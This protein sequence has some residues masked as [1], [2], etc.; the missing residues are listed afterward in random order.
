MSL[1]SLKIRNKLAVV[2]G[3]LAL[4]LVLMSW[5]FIQQS[6]KD[7]DFAIKEVAGRTYLSGAWPVL[8]DLAAARAT[9]GSSVSPSASAL[10]S[11]GATYDDSLDIGSA[12]RELR[13]LLAK[14]GWPPK[15]EL[16]EAQAEA[17]IAGA[18]TLITKIS[19]G[20]NLTLDPD[21]D[22]YYVMDAATTKLPEAVDKIAALM[23]LTRDH[24]ARAELSD[25]DKASPIVLIGL[26]KAA[27]EGAAASIDSAAKGNPSGD[28]RRRLDGPTKAFSDAAERFSAEAMKVVVAMREDGKRQATDLAG[29]TTRAGE[30]LNAADVLWRQSADQLD[31]LLRARVNGFRMRLATMLGLSGI[32]VTFALLVV[33]LIARAI[34]KPMAAMQGAM[35]ALAQ[36][37][38]DVALPAKGRSDEI[39]K[40]SDMLYVLRD[41]LADAQRL[42]AEQ[43]AQE[44]RAT[45][46]QAAARERELLQQHAAEE[47]SASERKMAMHKLAAEFE[48]A[49]GGIIEGVSSAAT[50]LE[51]A[52]K[53]LTDT[54]EAT[55]QL[56]ATV[57][58][59]S[60]QAS[61]NVQSV[62]SAT[63]EMTASVH[64]ISRQVGESSTI[65]SEAVNQAR[66]TDARIGELSQAAN[67]IGDVIKLITAV[68]EQTNLLA[69]NATIEAARAGEAGKGFAV[70]AQEVKALASQTAKAT[71]EIG[72]QIVNMQTATRESVGAINQIGATIVR[73]SE[74]ASMIADTVEQQDAATREIAGNVQQAA[75]STAEV[76]TNI[77]DVNRG[78]GETGSASSQVLASAQSL[79]RES[80]HLKIE[81][82]KFLQ[83]VRAA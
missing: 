37:D 40:M 27:A 11:L 54:A 32:I 55:Q 61:S 62:A 9:P 41:G 72:T 67:R 50:E 10:A 57:A 33:W 52:A 65:A 80:S 69:L 66:E 5:L 6:F 24:K 20:S 78:A 81:V 83:T 73:I 12:G 51:A 60:E 4:P 59:A 14:L 58:S 82:Q 39:G 3:L 26:F 34:T 18:R 77:S 30:A 29:V 74:I 16:M 44:I 63:E 48:R 31:A 45:E 43:R 2:V 49:V 64:E 22:S 56:S 47:K 38:L 15:P 13:D 35:Q 70:V 7:I 25:D 42:Q 75:R 23:A 8:R 68:A 46:E 1:A 36:G 53:S 17:A 79:A 28:V 76:A 19:D 21:L 71:G